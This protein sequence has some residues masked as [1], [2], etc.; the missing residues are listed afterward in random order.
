MAA[1]A[2]AESFADIW[3]D[4][5]QVISESGII[6]GREE[7]EELILDRIRKIQKNNHRADSNVVC[8]GLSK[9][10]GLDEKAIMMSL[11][12]MLHTE[13]VRKTYPKGK[14]SLRIVE[15][16]TENKEEIIEEPQDEEKLKK[17]RAELIEVASLHDSQH[18][19]EK[20]ENERNKEIDNQDGN[21]SEYSE[22][23]S[24]DEISH[25]SGFENLESSKK[26]VH[27]VK[28]LDFGKTFETRGTLT[29]GDILRR[30]GAIEK[31]IDQIVFSQDK[32][33]ID[34]T[35]TEKSDEKCF[36]GEI[37]FQRISVLERENKSLQDENKVLKM[38][39]EKLKR[40]DTK[41]SNTEKSYVKNSEGESNAGKSRTEIMETSRA[42]QNSTQNEEQGTLGT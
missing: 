25:E 33:K 19:E 28:F 35:K 4:E 16:E 7:L 38:E 39:I 6:M 24:D 30:I 37:F 32:E 41:K 8:K 1:A 31:R 5:E 34:I 12:Y 42:A 26:E 13:K 36:E 27:R 2:I 20:E 3:P 11:N 29:D 21:V 18:T 9:A 17:C 22:E 23:I 10:H 15:K 14:E 40:E